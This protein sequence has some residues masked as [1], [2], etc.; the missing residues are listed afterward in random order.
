VQ[1]KTDSE[2]ADVQA[3][4]ARAMEHGYPYADDDGVAA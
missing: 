4:A 2:R 3:R 1:T